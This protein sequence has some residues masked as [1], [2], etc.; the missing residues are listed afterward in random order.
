[1][2]DAQAAM[3]R[4]GTQLINERKAAILQDL[5]KSDLPIPRDILT[6]LGA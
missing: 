4:I 5:P 6:V 3:Q 1:M 2:Q